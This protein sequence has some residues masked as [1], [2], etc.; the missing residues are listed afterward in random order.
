MAS[1]ADGL[2]QADREAVARLSGEERIAL[3][4]MLGDAD[5]EALQQARGIDRETAVRVIRRQRQAGRQ[6]SACMSALLG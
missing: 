3:A 2:R 1:V 5:V 6:P 4:L